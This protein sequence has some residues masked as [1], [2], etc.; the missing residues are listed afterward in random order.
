MHL[1][2]ASLPEPRVPPQHIPLGLDPYDRRQIDEHYLSFLIVFARLWPSYL[3][4]RL[5]AFYAKQNP[6]LLAKE[7]ITNEVTRLV[8]EWAK[9]RGPWGG[10]NLTHFGLD[11]VTHQL[12]GWI[13]GVYV[14][15]G[16]EM[17]TAEYER[18]VRCWHVKEHIRMYQEKCVQELRNLGRVIGL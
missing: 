14:P 10:S 2:P 16:Q 12:Y 17:I 5:N 13:Q 4:P 18:A 11:R 15:I 9:M 7:I 6:G 3:L 8:I 1:E